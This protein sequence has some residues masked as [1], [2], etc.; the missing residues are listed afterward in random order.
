MADVTGRIG[1]QDVALDNAAT[2]ATLKDLLA[3]I[4]GQ[5]SVLSKL[6]GTAGQA[7]INPQAIAAANKGVQQM[8]A[9]QSAGVVAGKALNMAFSGLSKGAMLLGGVLGDIVAGGVQT[10]CRASR[11]PV[12]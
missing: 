11:C 7:G 3:A 8:S 9:A 1:D 4:K 10:G 6:S 12:R 5:T 2:E